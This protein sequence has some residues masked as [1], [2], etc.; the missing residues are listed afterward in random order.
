MD[1][2][3]A[4]LF[5]VLP[6]EGTPEE[7][8]TRVSNFCQNP[9]DLEFPIRENSF[10]A[11]EARWDARR[12]AFSMSVFKLRESNLPSKVGPDGEIASLDLDKDD[13]LGE[14]IVFCYYPD[15]EVCIVQHSQTGPR[16]PVVREVLRR[17][18]RDVPVY[19][20]PVLK[21]DMVERLNDARIF[22]AIEF[23]IKSPQELQ[24]F[25]AA[26]KPV[27]RALQML[28]DVDGNN[29]CVRISMG[30]EKGSMSNAVKKVAQS[31]VD[32]GDTDLGVLKVDASAGEGEPVEQ[33]DMLNAR[34]VREFEVKFNG[35]EM[36]R[37]DCCRKLKNLFEG[38]R[39]E[40]VDQRHAG[41]LDE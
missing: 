18:G 2:S 14:P 36:D 29:V 39:G 1:S 15:L 25:R 31:L 17:V 8:K 7:M 19:M 27:S 16:H 37:D 23:S 22:R 10:L 12:G 4:H 11:K 6:N 24:D 20:S 32:L 35:R 26:G 40:I 28:G 9:V 21:Q 38:L 13:D 34:M 3:K 30:H 5:W 41:V 33:L